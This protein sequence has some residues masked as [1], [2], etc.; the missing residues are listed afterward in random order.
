MT[1]WMVV[2]AV[3]L[4]CALPGAAEAHN[5]HGWYWGTR[6]A[7]RRAVAHYSDV[8]ERPHVS[9]RPDVSERPDYRLSG[10]GLPRS[11]RGWDAQQLRRQARSLLVPRRGGL[12]PGSQSRLA[13]LAF[14][15]RLIGPELHAPGIA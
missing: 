5:S 10:H 4:V 12:G 15:A 2:V 9:K 14:G 3:A 1:R 11:L 7:E 13:A 8:S 6:Y